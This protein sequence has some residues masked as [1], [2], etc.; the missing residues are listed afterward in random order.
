VCFLNSDVFPTGPLWLD[1]LASHLEADPTL[2]AVGPMLLYEDG[3]VQHEGMTLQR[4]PQFGNWF[5]GDH[6]RKAMKPEAA[7]GLRDCVGITGAC[8][9]LKH[10]TAEAL[11]G[12]DDGYVIGDFEDSDLCLRLQQHGLRCAVDLGEQ[13]YHLERKSQLSAALRWRM[14][15]TVYNAWLHHQRWGSLLGANEGRVSA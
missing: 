6:P 7:A 2:G 14:N 9:V 12:F 13:L 8:M 3:S 1:R 11:G 4:L 10:M 15:L 5:F